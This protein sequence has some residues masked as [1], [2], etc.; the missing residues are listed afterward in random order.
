[1]LGVGEGMAGEDG[2]VGV[3]WGCIQ[4]FSREAGIPDEEAF[5]VFDLR[6]EGRSNHGAGHLEEAKQ[7]QSFCAVGG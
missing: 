4:R 1:M 2:E 6:I 3:N 5:E 7:A